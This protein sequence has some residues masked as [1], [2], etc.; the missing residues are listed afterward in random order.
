VTTDW[1]DF[2]R[3]IVR[4]VSKIRDLVRRQESNHRGTPPALDNESTQPQTTM[5]KATDSDALPQIVERTIDIGRQRIGQVYAKALLAATEKSGSHAAVAELGQLVGELFEK[6]P[7]F[8]AALSSPRLTVPEKLSLI[9]KTLAGGISGELL[10]FV[11]VICEHGRLDCLRSIYVA[12][13]SMRNE[14]RGVVQV[15]MV[16]AS[17][18]D[19]ATV[20]QVKSRLQEQLGSEVDLNTATDPKLIGGVLLRIG[21]KVY[22]GSVARKLELLRDQAIAATVEEIRH[23][24]GK[25]STGEDFSAKEQL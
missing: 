4:R 18:I 3:K 19:A 8:E 25:F 11:K 16:T 6:S 1:S 22:D 7:R 2:G 12:A 20:E 13:R 17:P 21:D 5:I 24:G 9:D 23:A 10:R 14:Q 15:K